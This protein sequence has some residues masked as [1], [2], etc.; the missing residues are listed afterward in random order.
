[1]NAQSKRQFS[2][3]SL[4]TPFWIGDMPRPWLW[5]STSPGISISVPSPSTRASGAR[6]RRSA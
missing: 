3:K 4:A 5:A 1:M 6:W 2:R